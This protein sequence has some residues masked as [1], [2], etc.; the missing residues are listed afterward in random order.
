MFSRQLIP[1]RCRRPLRRDAGRLTDL[2]EVPVGVAQ[3]T[4][5]LDAAV[6]RRCQELR[7]SRSPLVVDAVDVGHPDVEEAGS[8]PVPVCVKGNT[9]CDI[10]IHRRRLARQAD[11]DGHEAR[12]GPRRR[13]TRPDLTAARLAAASTSGGETLRAEPCRPS[14]GSAASGVAR[15]KASIASGISKLFCIELAVA[16]STTKSRRRITPVSVTTPRHR[17]TRSQSRI[18]SSAVPVDGQVPD[19]LY[20]ARMSLG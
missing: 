10:A 15:S 8:A 12:Q 17:L 7:A 18:C 16:R 2:D 5:K 9:L 11:R 6:G 14:R 4:A 1:R 19:D 20:A 3:V 13:M